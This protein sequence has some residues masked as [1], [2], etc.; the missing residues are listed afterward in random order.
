[1]VQ[2][3]DVWI[4]EYY[5]MFLAI[6]F[7]ALSYYLKFTLIGYDLLITNSLT[8]ITIFIGFVGTLSGIILSSNGKSIAFMKKIGKLSILLS[9]IWRSLHVSFIFVFYC[10][11]LEVNKS[12]INSYD[13]VSWLWCF[14]GVYSLLQIHRAITRSAVL[15]KSAASE[16]IW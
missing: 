5:P 8:I 9:Y 11:L 3:I 13:W 2:R 16:D 7:G 15:L 6:T 1:M 12:L 10:I 4:E 14:L